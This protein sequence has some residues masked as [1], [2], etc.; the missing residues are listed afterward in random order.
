MDEKF[1][2][3][4]APLE[5]NHAYDYFFY[6]EAYTTKEHKEKIE[7]S[8]L[9]PVDKDTFVVP[10]D[11]SVFEKGMLIFDIY[12]EIPDPIFS[13]GICRKRLKISTNYTVQ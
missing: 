5:G 8:D 13:N 2:L 3:T 1:I 7:K 9:I 12:A 10:I 6:I 11:V 4:I